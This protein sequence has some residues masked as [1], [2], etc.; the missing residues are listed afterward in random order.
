LQ[1]ALGLNT[2]G[3]VGPQTLAALRA[4]E[5]NPQ[6]LLSNLRSSREWYERTV[7]GRNE[8][9]QFWNGLVNRWN[10]AYTDAKSFGFTQGAA[11]QPAVSAPA[12]QQTA[13]TQT[14][15]TQQAKPTAPT[16]PGPVHQRTTPTA[17]ATG[18][19]PAPSIATGAASSIVARVGNRSWREAKGE[20]AKYVRQAIE[21]QGITLQRPNDGHGYAKNYGPGLQK[22]GFKAIA[23]PGEYKVGDVVVIQST[24]KSTAGH[25]QIYTENG[26][27][28]DHK[29][30]GFWPGPSY[31]N[32]EPA[33]TVYRR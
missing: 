5:A 8:Q 27:Y 26:W 16:A 31:R 7:V 23:T 17:P 18:N 10:N 19:K 28:S 6:Q 29:Q 22:A 25:M 12:T 30:A 20:C 21:S 11:N 9:S 33:F 15:P 14:Q 1:H 32:E 2:D 24:S 4:A 3:K 13:P